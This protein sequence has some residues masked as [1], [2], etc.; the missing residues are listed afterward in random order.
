[1]ILPI[2]SF[3]ERRL[4]HLRSHARESRHPVAT[5]LRKCDPQGL[6]GGW[7]QAGR[8]QAVSSALYGAFDSSRG[9]AV[10]DVKW[11]RDNKEAFIKG[12]ADRGFEASA[13]AMLNRILSLDEQ[14]RTAV[15]KMQDA[16]ARRNTASKKIGKTKASR[17]GVAAKRLKDKV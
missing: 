3:G 9:T 4:G 1:M 17:E 8:G 7:V 15:R 5:V 6:L 10:L 11:I 16:Q 14:R 12:L 2:I 13:R